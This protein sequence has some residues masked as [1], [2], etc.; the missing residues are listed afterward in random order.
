MGRGRIRGDEGGGEG[1]EGKGRKK[2]CPPQI[3]KR[4]DA[5][6]HNEPILLDSFLNSSE[7][8]KDLAW[9]RIADLFGI[10]NDEYI[11]A[12]IKYRQYAVIQPFKG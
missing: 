6:V 9:K 10:P 7:D 4:G 8:E 1:R 5:T 2:L 11:F 12:A 3:L